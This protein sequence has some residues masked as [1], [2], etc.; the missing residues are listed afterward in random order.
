[1][2]RNNTPGGLPLITRQAKDTNN[3]AQGLRRLLQIRPA[4]ASSPSPVETHTKATYHPIPSI[5]RQRIVTQQ[6]LNVMTIQEQVA[7]N[8]A[9]TPQSLKPSS[10][11][12]GPMK[13]EHYANPMVHPIKG[14]T[15]LSYKKLMNNPAT[16]EVWQTACGKD[17]GG[18]CQG[19]NKTGQKGT[20]PMFVMTHDKIAH[21]LRAKRVFTYG[22]QV[23]DH[24][25]QKEDSNRIRITAGGN[26][27]NCEEEI[28]VRTADIN[29]AKLHWNSVISTIG[30]RYMCLNI[31]N[32]YLTAALEYF[33]Y[34]GMPLALF[35]EWIIAQY[36]LKELA[37]N[38]YVHL[39]MRKAVW[40]LPQ[41]GILANKRLK[42]K[43]A[44]FRYYECVNTP[45]LWYH[46]SRPI[47]FTLVVVLSQ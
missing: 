5:A 6:A 42:W 10:W 32:F 16:A 46:V 38:G 8:V 14:E 15:I 12:H 7:N 11:T 28:S 4:I 24:R 35:P 13:F 29:T 47:S 20:N 39:K 40:G 9:F 44:P 25:P 45:G 19:D 27:I 18:M 30:A 43:L 41:A 23:V 26:L 21:A 31:G 34:M 22:N 33:E 17:F 2:T 36:N 1:M 37:L 3:E